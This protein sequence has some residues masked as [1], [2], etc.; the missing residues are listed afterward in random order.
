VSLATGE[1]GT[2]FNGR[3]ARPAKAPPLTAGFANH[4]AFAAHVWCGS[5]GD[6]QTEPQPTRASS[7]ASGK[8][9]LKFDD[10]PAQTFR[11]RLRPAG[12]VELGE[13]S[14]QVKF[15]GVDR[16]TQPARHCFVA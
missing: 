15:D 14:L 1:S 11:D 9:Q 16:N 3:Y 7:L 6:I 10:T 5:K 4:P 13:Q 2:L 12:C 8:S